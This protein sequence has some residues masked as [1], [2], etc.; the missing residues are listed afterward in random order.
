MQDGDLDDFFAAAR[1]AGPVPSEALMARVVA[2]AAA[3]QPR[4]A[5]VAASPS[6]PGFWA[7]LAG[8]FG[9]SGAM[10]GLIAATIGGLW[11]GVV[12]PGPVATLAGQVWP[13]Q[14]AL[15]VELIPDIF[16]ALEPEP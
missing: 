3:L 12:Q 4:P 5:P 15:S 16:A 14:Q 1:R 10:G 13:T 8:V 11:I 6:G 9:R 2:D 7:T